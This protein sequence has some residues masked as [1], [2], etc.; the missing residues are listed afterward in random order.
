MTREA[1]PFVQLRRLR[2]VQV[3]VESVRRQGA[4]QTFCRE[5]RVP[6]L[7]PAEDVAQQLRRRVDSG[8][9]DQ[10]MA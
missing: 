6:T 10:K 3:S 8:I 2:R 4:V 5:V 7:A 1:T 9:T